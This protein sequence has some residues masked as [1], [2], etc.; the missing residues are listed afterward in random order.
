M[1]NSKQGRMVLNELIALTPW[2]CFNQKIDIDLD[3]LVCFLGI[4]FN[5]MV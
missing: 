3:S 5:K 2:D 1:V 4:F